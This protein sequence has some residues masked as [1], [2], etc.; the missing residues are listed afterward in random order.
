MELNFHMPPVLSVSVELDELGR[1][2]KVYSHG[3]KLEKLT[4]PERISHVRSL[5]AAGTEEVIIDI[6]RGMTSYRLCRD[7]GCATIFEKQFPTRY[8]VYH[9]PEWTKCMNNF[10]PEVMS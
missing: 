9:Q 2:K 7:Q 6:G 10:D 1:P 3:C 4:T 5:L 8:I